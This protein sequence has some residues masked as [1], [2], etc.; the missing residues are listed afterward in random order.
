MSIYGKASVTV[1]ALLHPA[2]GPASGTLG[3]YNNNN[4][5]VYI[6]LAWEMGRQNFVSVDRLACPGYQVPEVGRPMLPKTDQ[7]YLRQPVNEQ[8]EKLSLTANGTWSIFN[9][10]GKA[11]CSAKLGEKPL[12]E[13]FPYG[14]QDINLPEVA[15]PPSPPETVTLLLQNFLQPILPQVNVQN[16]ASGFILPM[17][18]EYRLQQPLLPPAPQV[19][20]TVPR[21]PLDERYLE[22]WFDQI[23]VS[24]Y[25]EII[26]E[27]VTKAVKVLTQPP[28]MTSPRLQVKP[29][30]VQGALTSKLTGSLRW[31]A[32]DPAPEFSTQ[33]TVKVDME[34]GIF[35]GGGAESRDV[36]LPDDYEELDQ[37]PRFRAQ[38]GRQI[39][40]YNI[41]VQ[42]RRTTYAP[43]PTPA[44]PSR[45]NATDPTKQ[46]FPEV[47]PE[48][49]VFP[50]KRYPAEKAPAPILRK[51]MRPVNMRRI[52]FGEAIESATPVPTVTKGLEPLPATQFTCKSAVQ[53]FSSH[54]F[55]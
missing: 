22:D 43:I 34:P 23:D 11:N 29:P 7:A 10:T 42:E 40:V 38:R 41:T 9:H 54:L 20:T 44:L 47:Q 27:F 50:P 55:F 3:V 45:V 1:V 49:M 37:S 51:P 30:P 19:F 15:T 2:R 36:A 4:G 13:N 53:Y 26:P 25:E 35:V 14:S 18:G 12:P 5:Q 48:R 52:K 32:E 8:P 46:E 17:T 31:L 6:S 24:D 39:P 21:S 28:S 16:L 33:S